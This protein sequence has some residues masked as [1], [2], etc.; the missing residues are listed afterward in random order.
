MSSSTSDVG[1]VYPSLTYAD[2]AAAIEWLCA[3]F[4]FER[5]LLV[6]GEEG[7]VRHSELSLGRAVVMVSSPKPE[8]GRGA[9]EGTFSTALSV[10]VA[11]PDAHHARAVAH[12]AEVVHELQDEEYGARGYQARD[13]EG[14]LWYFG[15]YRPGAW[16][17]AGG[18]D[19]RA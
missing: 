3:A 9:P 4:G 6:P 12:G 13:L 5:R 18:A 15:N 1:D 2:A 7:D 8:Q 14:R 19:R 10:Y 17:D 16:W 11:D